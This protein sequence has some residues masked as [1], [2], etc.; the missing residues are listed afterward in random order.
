MT[1]VEVN[2]VGSRQPGPSRFTLVELSIT[3]H[4][5]IPIEQT[6]FDRERLDQKQAQKA[7]G[8]FDLTARINVA[9]S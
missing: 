6:W 9:E 4:A 7:D 3:L 2:T 8:S 1:L 5:N